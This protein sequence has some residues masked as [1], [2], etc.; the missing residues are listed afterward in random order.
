MV[1]GLKFQT[2]FF[3][4]SQIK[5][6]FSGLEFTKYN[7]EGPDLI[8]LLLLSRGLFGRQLATS[9]LPCLAGVHTMLQEIFHDFVSFADIFQN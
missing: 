5:F 1:N 2:L 8:R 7:T 3:F 4:S 9:T 6:W